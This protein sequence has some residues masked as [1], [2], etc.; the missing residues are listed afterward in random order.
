MSNILI[1][2]GASF[3]GSNFA[4]YLMQHTKYTVATLDNLRTGNLKNLAPAQAAKNRHT[5]YLADVKDEYISK[6]IFEIEKPTTVIYNCLTD[7]GTNWENDIELLRSFIWSAKFSFS[8]TNF[9][10]LLPAEYHGSIWEQAAYEVLEQEFGS[11]FS[12]WMLIKPCHVFGPRQRWG[13][14]ADTIQAH[15]IGGEMPNPD[16]DRREWMYVKDYFMKFMQLID[17]AK[18][19]LESGKYTLHTGQWASD[20]DINLFVG[21]VLSG[22]T[23]RHTWEIDLG[24]PQS[25]SNNFDLVNALEHTV[26]WYDKNRW[27]WK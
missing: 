3:I 27:S 7:A 2:G 16:R 8:I 17:V 26:V 14:V 1:A 10:V 22:K 20:A 6:K 25:Q 5:F 13:A 4:N 18:D 12:N 19:E 23:E 15:L 11:G 21:D 9:I 24:E